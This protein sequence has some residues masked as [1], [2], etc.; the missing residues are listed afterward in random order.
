MADPV[1]YLRLLEEGEQINYLLNSNREK[2]PN[3]T[4]LL[5]LLKSA[6][7]IWIN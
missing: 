7:A 4:P 3:L 6:I 1:S 2:N 5:V